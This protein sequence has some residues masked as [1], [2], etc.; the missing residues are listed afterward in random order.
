MTKSIP[1][2]R[3]VVE[4]IKLRKLKSKKEHYLIVNFD[5]EHVAAILDEEAN[6]VERL[7]QVSKHDSRFSLHVIRDYLWERAQH[8][9]SK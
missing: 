8:L 2:Y 3:C 6:F 5:G 4:P 9:R 7:I 1:E